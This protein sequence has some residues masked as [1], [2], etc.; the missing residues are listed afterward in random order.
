MEIKI[1]DRESTN[2][3]LSPFDTVHIECH[4]VEGD[5]T[6]NCSNMLSHQFCWNVFVDCYFS[7]I[8]EVCDMFTLDYIIWVNR[9]A[10]IW[11][12]QVTVA[13]RHKSRLPRI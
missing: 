7:H 2:G 6:E 5:H 9:S 3:K 1:A 13:V 4:I 10:S 11:A 8:D 12:I